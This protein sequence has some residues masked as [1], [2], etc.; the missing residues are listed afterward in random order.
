MAFMHNE[1]DD[2]LNEQLERLTRIVE[3]DH[4][5][6]KGMYA[7]ARWASAFRIVYWA[8]I[9]FAA[10]GTYV[11]VQPYIDSFKEAYQSVN[12]FRNSVTGQSGFFEQFFKAAATTTPR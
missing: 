6:I 9:V 11:Y 8:V 4:R 2:K 10:F 1:S 5:L 12:Q 3:E 7:R